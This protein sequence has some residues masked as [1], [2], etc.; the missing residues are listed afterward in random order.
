MSIKIYL[1]FFAF[2]ST[3]AHTQVNDKTQNSENPTLE[4]RKEKPKNSDKKENKDT[5]TLNLLEVNLKLESIINLMNSKVIPYIDAQN[6]V[7]DKKHED[8]VSK[9]NT[10]NSQLKIDLEAKQKLVIQYLDDKK[11]ND[12][13][14]AKLSGQVKGNSDLLLKQKEQLRAEIGGLQKQSFKIDDA[15]LNSLGERLKV[16]PGVEASWSQTYQDFKFKR[17]LLFQADEFLSKP[18]DPKMNKLIGEIN[19]GFSSGQQF[20]ELTKEKTVFTKLLSGYCEKTEEM[21]SLLISVSKL[22]ALKD[23]RDKKINNT[24]YYYIGYDYLISIILKN[25]TDFGHNPIKNTITDCN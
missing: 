18:Y 14:I 22:E 9:I 21:K 19:T 3:S 11:N 16:I 12:I 5:I 2:V 25:K 10:A 23:E 24:M 8:E 1:F 17:N 15:I 20:A 6:S 7:Q 13:E 4:S